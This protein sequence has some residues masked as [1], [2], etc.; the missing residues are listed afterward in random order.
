[1]KLLK[2]LYLQSLNEKQNDMSALPDDTMSELRK[3]IKKGAEDKEQMWANALE[4][5]HKAYEVSGVE[6][7]TPELT[8]GWKQYEENI[9][10][11]VE[12]LSHY[13][14]LDGDWRMSSHVFHEAMEPTYKFH[15]SAVGGDFGDGYDVMAKNIDEI[16]DKIN[17]NNVDEYDIDREDISPLEAKLMFS[18]W[19]I[20]KNYRLHIKRS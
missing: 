20:K 19:G 13:R 12:Q 17:D 16:I 6:R 8:A 10:Y 15:V 7:P 11:A 3:N 4:L 2:T 14:G 9:Q 1:M 18:K 5:V